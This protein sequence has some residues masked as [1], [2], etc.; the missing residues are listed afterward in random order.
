M[1]DQIDF[2]KRSL[3]IVIKLRSFLEIWIVLKNKF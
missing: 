3:E 1:E 2:T